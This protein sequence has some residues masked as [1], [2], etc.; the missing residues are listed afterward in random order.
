[1]PYSRT[2]GVQVYYEVSGEGFPLVLLHANPFDHNLWMYQIAHFSTYFR[3]VSLDMRGYGRSDKPT[4]PFSLNDLA[5]DVLGVCETEGISEAIVAGVSTGSGIA[6]LLGLDHPQM[7]KAVI[8]V[9]GS[10]GVGAGSIS[11]SATTPVQGGAFQRR[12]EGYTTNLEEHHIVHMRELVTPEFHQS[13][14]GSYL[15]STFTERDPWLSGEALAQV[16]RARGGTD[17]TPRLADMKVPTLVINGEFD[18]SLAGGT[19]TASLIPG[20]VHKILPNTGHACCIEDPAGFDAL[21][22]D[23]LR[24][25]GLMPTLGKLKDEVTPGAATM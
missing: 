7:F 16:F 6:L 3:V 25:K 23:F 20:S 13:K 21:V 24:S 9:G 18:I 14:L 2:N 11:E 10:S 12:I 1:M 4:T 17:M 22:V 8:L 5:Q 19:R 15:L